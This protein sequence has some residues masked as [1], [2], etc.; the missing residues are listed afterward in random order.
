MHAERC[1]IAA[2]VFVQLWCCKERSQ[3]LLGFS[4]QNCTFL[5]L[6]LPKEIGQIELDKLRCH[7]S[8]LLAAS[9]VFTE[10]ANLQLAP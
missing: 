5:V 2:N 7:M 8:D 6:I 9:I 4:T 1:A 10:V 3:T